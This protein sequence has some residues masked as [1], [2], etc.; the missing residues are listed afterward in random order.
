L[1]V[2]C[3]NNP[4]IYFKNFEEEL[5]WIVVNIFKKMFTF[6]WCLPEEV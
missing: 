5:S 2:I 6:I 3:N 1:Y 4:Q